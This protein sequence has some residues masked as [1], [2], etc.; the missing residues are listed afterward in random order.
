MTTLLEGPGVASPAAEPARR[1]IPWRLAPL[2][3]LLA[4]TAVAYLWI[5]S[6]SGYANSFYSAAAQAGS[7]S[8]KAFLFGSL[9][10]GNAITV[11][12][13]P[14]S[15][16]LMGL[17]VRLFGLSS[18]SIL[19]PQALLGVGTVWL[20][21]LTVRRTSTEA[22]ALAAGLLTALTP[23]AVLMFR[24]NNPDALLLFVLVA[25]GYCLT[26]ALEKASGR[27]LV[28]AG[29]LVGLGFL[30]KMLQAFLVLPAFVLVYLLAAPTSFWRR[31]RQLL[32]ACVAMLVAAGWWVALVEL[33][34]ESWR[35]YIDGSRDNS[36]L[37][38]IWGYNG[39]S[40]I[41][42]A[43]AGGLGNGGF[44]SGPG[45]LRLFEGVSGGMIAWLLPAALFLLVAGVVARGRRPRTDLPRAVL[46]LAGGTMLT[47]GA[48]FSSMEGIYHDYYTV[49]LAPWIAMTAVVGFAILWRG[50]SH[51]LARLALAAVVIGS[52]VWAWVLLGQPETQPYDTLRWLVLV[53]GVV[54]GASL[55]VTDLLDRL[56]RRLAA[57][58][59]AAAVVVV[60]AGPA[61]YAVQTIGTSHTGSIVTAGPDRATEAGGRGRTGRPAGGGQPGGQTGG[62]QP[63]GQTGGG[64]T[65]G[66][67]PGGQTGGG[68]PG[69]QTGGGQ[70]GGQTGGGQPGGQT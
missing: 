3:A 38:L 61:S 31:T 8:W 41:T 54:V 69:G 52:A 33:V 63:G 37:D 13:P 2:A 28:L 20:V 7:Q 12:K 5:L 46:L 55:A 57:V 23:S 47:T 62:G 64:Q 11:D 49:A 24:F 10:P 4:G 30:T 21:Y 1:R 18:W 67:Q 43:A 6:E 15:L 70:P 39:L 29:V 19:V 36:V 45:P 27:W 56:H 26:R 40:R 58:V 22:A 44:S 9:D 59:V 60:G 65:G 50:R 35:P 17:S 42:G 25:A 32:Y 16:W 51:L 68:Q 48:V 53:A 34:P 14:A 66:G